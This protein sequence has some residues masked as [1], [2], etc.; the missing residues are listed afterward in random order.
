MKTYSQL[1][2]LLLFSVL[3]PAAQT[4]VRVS[5][6]D[7]IPPLIKELPDWETVFDKAT[8]TKNSAPLK[9]ALGPR[10]VIELIDF[11]GGT[12]AVTA[13]YDEGKLL[14]I[15]Y[16]TPQASVAA[17]EAFNAKLVESPG[18]PATVYRRI[19][20]FNAFVFDAADPV[21]AGLLLDRVK[22]EK[23]VQWLGKDPN[24][25]QKAER[26][27]ARSTADLFISTAVAIVTAFGFAVLTGIVTGILFYRFRDRQRA[28]MTAYSDAG[29]M[30]RLNLDD[31]T[32]PI[33]ADRLLN[34]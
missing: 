21:A 9:S 7:G 15:E 23:T 25:L 4:A 30:V 32:S 34:E 18:N 10:E 2:L 1:I 13:Q 28:A 26:Y 29:G 6:D 22:Y 27:L 11:T 12:Q 33:A 20:N 5:D 14:I 16:P 19:G 31:L 24:Y 17:D 8:I 3:S